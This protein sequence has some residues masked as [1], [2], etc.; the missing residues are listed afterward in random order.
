MKTVL[1]IFYTFILLCLFSSCHM[2][3]KCPN[4]DEDILSW[5]PYENGSSLRNCFEFLFLNFIDHNFNHSEHNKMLCGF[6]YNLVIF[7]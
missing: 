1:N 7:G 2:D 6:G 4:F 3:V 5:Y